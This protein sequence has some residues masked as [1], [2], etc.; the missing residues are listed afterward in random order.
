MPDLDRLTAAL[1][2][3]LPVNAAVAA[4]DPTVDYPLLAGETITAV[5]GRLQ[6]QFAWQLNGFC[7]EVV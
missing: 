5:P 1:R 3:I 4:T 2:A 6:P 7:A